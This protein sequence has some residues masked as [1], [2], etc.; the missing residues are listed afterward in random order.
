MFN[1]VLAGV[2][3]DEGGRDAVAL[4]KTLAAEDGRL[5]FAY[6]YRGD[7]HR[8]R[9][10]SPPLEA[11][12]EEHARQLLEK[13]REEAG[14]TARVRWHGASTVG[15]GL[16]ELA[17]QIGADVLVVGS[18]RR[19]LMGRVLLGNDT[20]AA[21]NGS[22]CAVAIAPAGYAR[23]PSVIREIGVGYN[24]SPESEHALKV[25]RALAERH[26]AKLSALEA[27]SI[28]E[29]VVATGPMPANDSIEALVE[30]ARKNISRLEE[31]EPHAVYGYPAEELALYSA[32]T[33]LLVLGSRSYGPIGRLMHGST[34]HELARKARCPLLVLTRA[35]READLRTVP[36]GVQA[37]DA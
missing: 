16:H 21:L 9:G 35:S 26:G 25:A 8:W 29:V 28:P 20:S 23:E 19:S 6:V 31:V 36:S 10:S 32:S 37:V 30:D 1:N 18:S 11:A 2:D 15:R 14:V 34:S 7:P 4:A 24:G 13:A 17:E 33:D 22:P 12:E 3:G 5:T 27:V